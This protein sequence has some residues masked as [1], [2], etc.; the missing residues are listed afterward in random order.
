MWNGTLITVGRSLKA[1]NYELGAVVEARWLGLGVRLRVLIVKIQVW[2]LLNRLIV[3]PRL[4][5]ST[6][7]ISH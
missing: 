4:P 6:S 3:L 1:R 2:G 7:H 5:R